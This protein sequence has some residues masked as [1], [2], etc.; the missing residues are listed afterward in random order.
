MGRTANTR[1]TISKE[2]AHLHFEVGIRLSAHFAQWHARHRKGQRNDHGDWNGQNLVGL[3]CAAL[4]LARHRAGEKFSLLDH[5]RAMPELCRVF[6]RTDKLPIAARMQ[7]L[8]VPNPRVKAEGLHGYE[9]ALSAEGIP[10][11]MIPRTKAEYPLS[12]KLTVLRVDDAVARADTCRKLL[13]PRSGKW[14]L[15]TTGTDLLE[16]MSH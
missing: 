4:L 9:I 8:V 3:D 11:M 7:P 1:E 13:T 2:R 14:Q 16:L 5:L 15:S 10:L 6:V 12:A